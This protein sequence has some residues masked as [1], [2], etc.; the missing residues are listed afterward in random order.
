[1]ISWNMCV[2]V[3]LTR[4]VCTRGLKKITET[5][6][7]IAGLLTGICTGDPSRKTQ[8]RKSLAYLKKCNTHSPSNARRLFAALL[9]PLREIP[10]KVEGFSI[11]EFCC[12]NSHL[13]PMSPISYLGVNLSEQ[14]GQT[15]A[16][17]YRT[18]RLSARERYG[19][20]MELLS[21]D[22]AHPGK[23]IFLVRHVHVH[24]FWIFLVR[25]WSFTKFC[26]NLCTD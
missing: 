15:S 25:H 3:I 16:R 23:F 14:N 18:E 24:Q 26:S 4:G 5:S 1:M 20:S 9:N 13:W 7:G 2:E 17:E 21:V 11:S 10:W 6:V 8:V 22:W 19:G 12:I